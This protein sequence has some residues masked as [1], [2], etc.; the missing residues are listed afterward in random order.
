[1]IPKYN[2]NEKLNTQVTEKSGDI[3]ILLYMYTVLHENGNIL[4]K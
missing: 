3:S 1:M 4:D 2:G